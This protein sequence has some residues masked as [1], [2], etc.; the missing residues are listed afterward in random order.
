MIPHHYASFR[1]SSWFCLEFLDVP[2]DRNFN[3]AVAFYDVETRTTQKKDNF[4]NLL[5]TCLLR[6]SE[7]FQA[8]LTC[9][10]QSAICL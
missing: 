1:D 9:V 8:G 2:D 3:A 4:R 6:F 5:F 7:H 10:L